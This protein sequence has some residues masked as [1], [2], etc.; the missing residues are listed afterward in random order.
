MNITIIGRKCTPREAFK[1]K[2][3]KKLAKVDKFFSHE[4]DAKI[5][6]IVEKSYQTVEITVNSGGMVFR[7]IYPF[8]TFSAS[9][10][11]ASLPGLE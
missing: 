2:A 11:R 10:T 8:L 7:A 5:T 4:A 6:A 9:A 1:E 3:E